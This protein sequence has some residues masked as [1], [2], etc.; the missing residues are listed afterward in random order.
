MD[1][2]LRTFLSALLEKIV[3][4]EEDQKSIQQAAAFVGIHRRR[5][6]AI[7]ALFLAVTKVETSLPSAQLTGS[8]HSLGKFVGSLFYV[9]NEVIQS[10]KKKGPEF[11]KGGAQWAA[12][13][14]DLLAVAKETALLDGGAT[15]EPDVSAALRSTFALLRKRLLRL[16]QVW[17]ERV[18]YPP[19][20]TAGLV[21][22]LQGETE[23]KVATH[24]AAVWRLLLK[25]D[26]ATDG[27]GSPMAVEM[28]R[29]ADAVTP[30][31]CEEWRGKVKLGA[32]SAPAPAAPPAA[33]SSS[34]PAA[35]SATAAPTTSTAPV[36]VTGE[37]V[38]A[39]LRAE[40]ARLLARRRPLTAAVRDASDG[41]RDLLM[42]LSTSQALGAAE[43]REVMPTIEETTKSAL[44]ALAAVD[45][46]AADVRALRSTLTATVQSCDEELRRATDWLHML[47]AQAAGL[48]AVRAR[49]A[50]AIATGAVGGA[51]APDVA[52]VTEA[53]RKRKADAVA[54]AAAGGADE[55]CVVVGA[56]KP[57]PSYA[58]IW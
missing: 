37:S 41:A 33:S 51:A 3:T 15:V 14:A 53:S 44:D 7:L 49:A 10:T 24:R 17:T 47:R 34:A 26:R 30:L 4:V 46:F 52:K 28:E 32:R 22:I 11:V 39:V 29:L 21:G 5:A 8:P 31:Y 40:G 35:V 54:A 18:V 12:L 56:W 42:T 23:D 9:V 48:T 20:L 43:A 25:D 6:P 55:E 19:A 13:T 36:A 57:L 2:N 45:S 27:S 58:T 38:P 50:D 1:D 16:L